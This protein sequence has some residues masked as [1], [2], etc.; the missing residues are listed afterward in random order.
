[1]AVVPVREIILTAT[2]TSRIRGR[3][4]DLAV[5]TDQRAR[6]AQIT[7]VRTTAAG[8]IA[9]VG[10]VDQQNHRDDERRS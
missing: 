2:A 8:K 5:D 9:R 3:G 7:K 10:I 6:I 4:L 1:M